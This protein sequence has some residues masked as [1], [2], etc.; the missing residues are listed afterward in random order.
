MLIV[1]C[2]SYGAAELGRAAVG[3]YAA[4]NTDMAKS[5]SSCSSEDP[6]GVVV[7]IH[8]PE[9]FGGWESC[10]VDQK[11]GESFLLQGRFPAVHTSWGIVRSG[12][13]R[14]YDFCQ[15]CF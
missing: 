11:L 12:F 4:V 9:G 2:C 6:L 5:M 14:V 8:V 10:L 15:G 1:Q 7:A 3:L 13:F